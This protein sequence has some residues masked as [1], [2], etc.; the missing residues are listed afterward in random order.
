[1]IPC[2][3]SG[4]WDLLQMDKQCALPQ[5]IIGIPWRCDSDQRDVRFNRLPISVR[6]QNALQRSTEIFGTASGSNP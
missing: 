6:I 2:V 5:S 3:Q 1:M 4:P